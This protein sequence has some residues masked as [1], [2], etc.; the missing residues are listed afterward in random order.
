[1]KVQRIDPV[2][3]ACTE[4]LT[5]YSVP[6]DEASQKLLK[7]LQ[8]GKLINATGYDRVLFRVK[9]LLPWEDE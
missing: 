6:V 4:C 3:C 2:G 5:G 1:M 7:K 9:V 8:K